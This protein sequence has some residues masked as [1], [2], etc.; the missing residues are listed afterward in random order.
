MSLDQCLITKNALELTDNRCCAC[1]W[2]IGKL[3]G[4]I[5]LEANPSEYASCRCIGDNST[6]ADPTQSVN[7]IEVLSLDHCISLLTFAGVAV[8]DLNEFAGVV[9][10][11]LE[12][13]SCETLQVIGR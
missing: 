9:V 5:S 7:L 1:L 6:V 3:R 11:P 10:V 8:S 4:N 2:P 12:T 13:D